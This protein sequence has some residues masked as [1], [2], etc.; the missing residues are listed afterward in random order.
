MVFQDLGLWPHLTVAKNLSFGLD[1]RGV[2]R[3]ER[4]AR[5]AAMLAKVGLSSLAHRSAAGLSGGE[6]QRVAIARALVLEPDAILLDEPL[7]HLDVGLRRELTALFRVLLEER[8]V[9]VLHVTH[10]PREAAAIGDRLAVL[11][12][13]E[14]VQDGSLEELRGRPANGFVQALMAELDSRGPS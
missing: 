1:A 13:G 6:R 10:D 2:A 8:K 11:D 7:T 5:V 9:T 3:S 12:G 14:I 4:D